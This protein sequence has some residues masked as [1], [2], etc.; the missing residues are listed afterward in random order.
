MGFL[1]FV[2]IILL[3]LLAIVSGVFATAMFAEAVSEVDPEERR[4]WVFT[5]KFFGPI[6]AAMY[7]FKRFRVEGS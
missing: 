3:L 5:V 4:H 6:G 7:Y 1:G 2:T